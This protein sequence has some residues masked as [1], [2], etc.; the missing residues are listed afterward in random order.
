MSGQRSDP[1]GPDVR[2]EHPSGE[3]PFKMKVRVVR[4]AMTAAT[5][6]AVV[7]SFAATVKW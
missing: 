3:V 4:A 6:A 1:R 5:L 7:Q 2:G